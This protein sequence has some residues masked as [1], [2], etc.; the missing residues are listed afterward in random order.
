MIRIL[1]VCHGNICRSPMAEFIMKDLVAKRGVA[2]KFYIESCAT[3][4]EEI[5]NS[6]Y[7]P[8][9]ATAQDFIISFSVMFLLIT[10]RRRCVPA[11]GAKVSPPV[12]T[13]ETFCISSSEKLSIRSEGSERLTWASSVQERRS[14]VSSRI[15]E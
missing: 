7:P 6:V 1:F 5:G 2:D 9:K 14:S 3:S 8:A 11:S 10:S 13:L 12:R 15:L 4:R